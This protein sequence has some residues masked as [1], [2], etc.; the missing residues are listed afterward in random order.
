M[1]Y[2]CGNMSYVTFEYGQLVKAKIYPEGCY[3]LL[4]K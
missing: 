4:D 3:F 1:D 2:E